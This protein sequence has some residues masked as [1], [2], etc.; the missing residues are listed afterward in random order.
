VESDDVGRRILECDEVVAESVE[1]DYCNGWLS[2][3][4][5]ECIEICKKV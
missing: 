5:D 1:S 2:T 4:H 3:F